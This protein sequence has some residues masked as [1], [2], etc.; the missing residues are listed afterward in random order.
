[1]VTIDNAMPYHV[2]I[3]DGA[4]VSVMSLHV[5]MTLQI[6][7]SRVTPMPS[8]RGL[9][10]DVVEPHGSIVLRVSFGVTKGLQ[11]TLVNFYIVG[12]MLPYEAIIMSTEYR[13]A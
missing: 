13:T 9:D 2:L 4:T 5:F 1:M 6:P 12:L 11:T 3:D 8:I 10:G 7:I